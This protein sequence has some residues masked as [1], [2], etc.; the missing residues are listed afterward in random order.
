MFEIFKIKVA[1]KFWE[2]LPFDQMSIQQWE[3][4]CDG[5]GYCCLIKLE[6]EDSGEVVNTSVTCRLLDT[7]SCL[8]KDYNN[9]LKSVSMC[10]KITADNL[11]ELL[12]KQNWLPSSCAYR[13]LHEGKPLPDWHPLLTGDPDSVHQAGVSVKRFALSEKFIH[14]DQLFDFV[15][16]NK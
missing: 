16:E 11:S 8:C 15:I 3:S 10:V 5:C 1:E 12:D 7:Q 14:P 13:L 2:T 9:R 4:L 6:D